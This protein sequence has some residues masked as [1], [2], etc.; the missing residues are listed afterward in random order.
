MVN[1]KFNQ[2]IALNHRVYPTHIGLKLNAATGLRQ[3]PPLL[4]QICR[5]HSLG[6]K[7]QAV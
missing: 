7:Q 4:R 1:S 2:A 5:Y 6:H 3:C